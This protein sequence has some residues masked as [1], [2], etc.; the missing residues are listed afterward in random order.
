MSDTRSCKL[1][2]GFIFIHFELVQADRICP[3]SEDEVLPSDQIRLITERSVCVA[4]H[5]HSLHEH[6]RRT[7]STEQEL[8]HLSK[9]QAPSPSNKS[10]SLE[11]SRHQY[12]EVT[13]R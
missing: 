10:M 2:M 11:F 7:Y 8:K 6:S 4:E 12:H 1:T 5:S 13:S 3:G 9:T